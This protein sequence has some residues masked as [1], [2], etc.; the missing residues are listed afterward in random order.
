MVELVKFARRF[1]KTSPLGD[2]IGASRRFLKILRT[3]GLTRCLGSAS[4][5]NPGP[6]VQTDEEL[7]AW[8][9]EFTTSIAR[10]SHAYNV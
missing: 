2:I 4:E 5:H 10:T 6:E 1:G 9:K 8:I 3:R 7:V